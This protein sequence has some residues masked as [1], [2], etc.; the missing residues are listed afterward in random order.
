ML[1]KVNS[2][3]SFS[4]SNIAIHTTPLKEAPERHNEAFVRARFLMSPRS[5]TQ[6]DHLSIAL[7]LKGK[8]MHASGREGG[9]ETVKEWG[10]SYNPN[11]FF[12][13]SFNTFLRLLS[14]IS[15]PL[16]LPLPPSLSLPLSPQRNLVSPLGLELFE[17]DPELYCLLPLLSSLSALP[18]SPRSHP[19][20]LG[21][22]G[23][24]TGSCSTKSS[25]APNP[26]PGLALL[27]RA[28]LVVP[29][30][31]KETERWEAR[32]ETAMGGVGGAGGWLVEET[33]HVRLVTFTFGILEKEIRKEM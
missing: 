19:S 6:I 1:E 12:P 16:F 21:G 23:G 20:A 5:S 17:G 26:G 33:R 30:H 18:P 4:H 15:I 32:G 7:R 14:P 3:S 28:S 2:Y 10:K 9:R 11:H 29:L 31:H 13:F 8:C 22:G 27:P 25:R 24:G